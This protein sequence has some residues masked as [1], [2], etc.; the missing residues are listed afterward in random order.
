MVVRAPLGFDLN[1]RR[2]PSMPSSASHRAF[3]GLSSP[4]HAA[5][6][7]APRPV[8]YWWPVFLSHGGA[9][10]SKLNKGGV[11]AGPAAGSLAW[12]SIQAQCDLDLTV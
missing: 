6:Q 7:S 4:R 3:V 10:L 12:P 5:E 9:A 2:R 8:R 1:A 11:R